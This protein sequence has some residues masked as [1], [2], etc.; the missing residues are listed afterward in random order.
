MGDVSDKAQD[1]LV[2]LKRIK[3][4]KTLAGEFI[5][6]RRVLLEY[7]Y[8]QNGKQLDEL[9]TELKDAGYIK[10]ESGAY[11]LLAKALNWQ[12]SETSAQNVT[13][14]SG[15]QNSNIAHLS[16]NTAQQ[17]NVGELDEYTKE[18]LDTLIDAVQKKDNSRIKGIIDGLIVSSPA[19][20][21]QILQLGLGVK[22]Q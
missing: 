13:I 22:Q 6:K 15:V 2:T 1:L 8:D 19:L 21:L 4:I 20:M 17:L 10:K 3:K 14:Y 18:K 7:G 11:Q 16:P 5:D 9:F 12:P